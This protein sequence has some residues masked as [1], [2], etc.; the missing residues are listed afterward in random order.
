MDKIFKYTLLKY[1]PSSVLDEQ[2]NVGILFIFIEDNKVHFTF[3][4]SLARLSALYPHTNLSN[5][6][7]YLSSFQSKANLLSSK[8]F[9]GEINADTIIEKEFF[10]ADANSFFFSEFKVGIYKSVEKTVSHFTNQYFAYYNDPSVLGHKDDKYLV[11]KFAHYIK[12][13]DK[14]KLFRKEVRLKTNNITANFDYC[15][16]NGTTNFVKSISFDLKQKE[17]IQRKSALCWAEMMQLQFDNQTHNRRFDFLVLPP[18]DKGLFKP[19]ENALQLLD[20]LKIQTKI[21]TE[22]DIPNYTHEAIE[23]VKPLELEF[24]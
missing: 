9:F 18:T 5:T 4:K 13:T 15:W 11:R 1:R 22:S 6:K 14:N 20:S 21:V 19:Y 16:Q 10:L 12:E 7:Q 3:P 8:H 23:T 17:T 2:V 24:V